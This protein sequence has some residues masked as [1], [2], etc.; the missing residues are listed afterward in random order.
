MNQQPPP[1]RLSLDISGIT[2]GFGRTQVLGDVSFRV[3]TG[4]V[5]CLV[6]HSGCGK[7]TLLRILAGIERPLAGCVEAEGLVL[8]GPGVFVEPEDRGIGFLFQ[9]YAL[10]PHLSVTD[11]ILFGLRR[12]ARATARRLA[13]DVL[14]RLGIEHLAERFPHMLS[15]GE[16]Q[17]VALARALAPRPGIMLLD[18]P[19]S[20]LDRFLREG[21]RAET[22]AILGD[23]GTTVVMVTHDPEEALSSGDRVILMR[24]GRVVQAGTPADL[25]DHP[26]DAHAA[27]FFASSNRIAGTCRN[28]RLATPL[29]DFPAPGLADGTRATAHIRPH[30]L[31]LARTGE[32]VEGVEGR[33]TRHTL[34]G[35]IE[36]V[37]VAVPGLEAD[38]RVRSTDR[39]ALEA[40][41]KVLIVA[42][43]EHVFVFPDENLA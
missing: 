12:H 24:A 38:L 23:L 30:I 34:L 6:G 29:G 41:D 5:A 37:R 43:A 27:E 36:E 13:G 14:A 7:T 28:G 22:L 3:P 8:S 11:N 26:A 31:R 39:T 20:N 9:D 32:G 42:P 4:Q 15:G 33:V 35:E 16:Q 10:F 19:F 18:E 40:G 2:H 21:V 1:A 25:F 17:R